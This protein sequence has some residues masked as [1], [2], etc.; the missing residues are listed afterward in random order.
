MYTVICG[1]TFRWRKDRAGWWSCLLPIT[2]PATGDMTHQL[3]RLWQD[4]EMVYYETS[5]GG[6]VFSVGSI[7][8][9]ACLLG[10]ETISRIT[11]NVLARFTAQGVATPATD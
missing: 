6:A 3:V 7:T 2:D 11:Q 10:D 8:Y 1:Q 4:D 5:S 9:P